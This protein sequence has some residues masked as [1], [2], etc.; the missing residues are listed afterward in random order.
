[1]AAIAPSGSP[2]DS[3]QR[4]ADVVRKEVSRSE[5]DRALDGIFGLAEPSSMFILRRPANLNIG[6]CALQRSEPV[7]EPS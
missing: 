5:S 6:G 4:A 7:P 3:Q 1:M 2:F